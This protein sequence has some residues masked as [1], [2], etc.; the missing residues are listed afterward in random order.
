M[1][2]SLGGIKAHVAKTVKKVVTIGEFVLDVDIHEVTGKLQPGR[3]DVRFGGN[4]VSMSLPVKRQRR[5]TAQATIHFVW[6]G[7]NV[8][9]VTC[10]DMDITAEADRHA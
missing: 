5:D 1:T 7:K 2:L 9:G 10:G 6:D 3:P 4:Q 8:A